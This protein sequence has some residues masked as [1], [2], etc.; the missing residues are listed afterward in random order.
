MHP[1]NF[2]VNV[3]LQVSKQIVHLRCIARIYP[4]MFLVHLAHNQCFVSL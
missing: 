2:I 1:I 3:C 4:E